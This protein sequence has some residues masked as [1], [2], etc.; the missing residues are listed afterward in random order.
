MNA[1]HLHLALNHLPIFALA[2]GLITLAW[3]RLRGP[4][5]LMTVGLVLTVLAGAGAGGTFLTGEP[6][7]EV[8]E[9]R[10]GF[11]KE[12][13]HEHEEAADFALWLTLAAAV[14]AAGALWW[15]RAG[16]D[17]SGPAV[18]VTLLIGVIAMVALA[19]TALRGGEISHPEI[20]SGAAAAVV[21]SHDDD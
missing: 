18:A 4:R 11:D 14:T 1:A 16:G 20:R 5:T 19:I 13:V 8:L 7:E 12:L 21:V 6:A 3:G 9:D 2:F 10:A 17:Y 15:S